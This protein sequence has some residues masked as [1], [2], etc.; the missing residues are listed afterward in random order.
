MPASNSKERIPK[1]FS[2]ITTCDPDITIMYSFAKKLDFLAKEYRFYIT[3]LVVDG[4]NTFKKEPHNLNTV[5][6]N[7]KLI[8][9][10]PDQRISQIDAF[11][12]GL[13]K[14]TDFPVFLMAPDMKENLYDIPIFLEKISKG[15]DI[16]AA[17]RFSRVGVSRPRRILTSA[18]NLLMRHLFNIPMHDFNTCMSLLSQ[19]ATMN[20]VNTPKDCPSKSLYVVCKHRDSIAEVPISVKEIAGRRSTYTTRARLET[21]LLRIKEALFFFLWY[22]FNK[23]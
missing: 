14:S 1:T 4:L 5:L 20:W 17:W 12:V 18:F 21:G 15:F 6:A 9:H 22:N 13:H 10:S 7:V 11:N 16:V 23:S 2:L 8:W 3:W 19:D